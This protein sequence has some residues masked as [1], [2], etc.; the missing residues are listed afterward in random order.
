[1]ATSEDAFRVRSS[2]DAG[3][4]EMTAQSSSLIQIESA[5]DRGSG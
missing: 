4:A 3:A 5:G 2:P 1:L